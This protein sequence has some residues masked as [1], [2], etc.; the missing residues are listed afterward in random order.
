VKRTTPA[1]APH[2]GS[3]DFIVL[4][5]DEKLLVTVR[6]HL[7]AKHFKAI[8]ELQNLFGPG[9]RP[10]RIWPTDGANGWMWQEHAVN[11][12]AINA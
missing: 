9:Y 10:L 4:R 3:L 2:V 1:V 8:A 6:P 12:P 7:Q 11:A 5:N